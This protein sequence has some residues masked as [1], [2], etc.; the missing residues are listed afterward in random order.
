[1]SW[2]GVVEE[3]V[4]YELGVLTDG[5]VSGAGKIGGSCI[6]FCVRLTF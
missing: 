5:A 4:E 3:D 1:M 2:L 6:D